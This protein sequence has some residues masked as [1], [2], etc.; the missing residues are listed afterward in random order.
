MKKLFNMPK[1]KTS[2]RFVIRT[3]AYAESAAYW[4]YTKGAWVSYKEATRFTQEEIKKYPSIEGEWVEADN[5]ASLRSSFERRIVEAARDVLAVRG[6]SWEQS[7]LPAYMERPFA[8]LAELLKD[9]DKLKRE[10]AFDA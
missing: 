6:K 9:Y 8:M 3:P 4:S 7:N 10:G 1:I 5:E 2:K